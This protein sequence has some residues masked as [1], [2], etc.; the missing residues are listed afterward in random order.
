MSKFEDDK[1]VALVLVIVF[2]EKDKE[3]FVKQVAFPADV[4]RK[5]QTIG[6]NKILVSLADYKN[7]KLYVFKKP[8]Q[9]TM[10]MQ[11]FSDCHEIQMTPKC[12]DQLRFYSHVAVLKNKIDQRNEA[13]QAEVAENV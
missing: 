8:S 6:K 10:T 2:D 7:D 12:Y 4:E 9:G 1:K 13:K 11:N 3:Q 5:Y